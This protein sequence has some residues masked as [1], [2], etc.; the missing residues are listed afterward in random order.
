M[1][2]N[3]F[4]AVSAALALALAITSF[5]CESG[6][7]SP[8]R[9]PTDADR[10]ALDKAVFKY[11]ATPN[12][13]TPAGTTAE[14]PSGTSSTTG[15]DWVSYVNGTLAYNR[16]TD[17]TA[18]SATVK[19]TEVGDVIKT[20]KETV[21]LDVNAGT[22]S[23]LAEATSLEVFALVDYT[24]TGTTTNCTKTS[25]A[26][27]IAEDYDAS[28][29]VITITPGSLSGTYTPSVIAP[30]YITTYNGA[31]GYADVKAKFDAAITTIKTLKSDYVT[32]AAVKDANT[33]IDNDIEAL[34]L[35]LAY[36]D[37][38]WH[39]ATKVIVS[40]DAA[41][42]KTTKFVDDNGKEVIPA[43]VKKGTAPEAETGKYT[44]L[45]GN[46]KTGS[47]LLTTWNKVTFDD[48]ND[49]YVTADGYKGKISVT[50]PVASATRDGAIG[51]KDSRILTI[52]DGVLTAP[53]MNVSHSDAA[54]ATKNFAFI[55]SASTVAYYNNSAIGV[56]AT[57]RDEYQSYSY[58]LQ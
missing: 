52:A 18:K 38:K 40:T 58:K 55:F 33:A 57:G 8:L 25:K 49:A 14:T 29:T 48:A 7:D 47:I 34:N 16:K 5:G 28:H 50:Y 24:A 22:W 56:T 51:Q 13:Y 41:N 44:L 31:N 35:E 54:A 3:L 11:V 53:K 45:S 17:A 46:Y 19:G 10:A 43:I 12:E 1:K 21:T 20:K 39:G 6:N 26:I 9:N 23:K 2:K 27:Q 30:G 32:T 37:A 36:I 42:T 15:Y 4:G